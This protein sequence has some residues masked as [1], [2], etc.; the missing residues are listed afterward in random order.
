[1]YHIWYTLQAFD[2]PM[3]AR[4]LITRLCRSEGGGS[5]L[6]VLQTSNLVWHILIHEYHERL[7]THGMVLSR[8]AVIEHRNTMDLYHE[9]VCL[10]V[11]A[12]ASRCQT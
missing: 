6:M 1:M 9:K 2:S 11:P 8:R 10:H 7:N 3:K 12:S 5:D 4:K